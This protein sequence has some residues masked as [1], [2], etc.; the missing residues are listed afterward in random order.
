[1]LVVPR[2]PDFLRY[3]LV[4]ETFCAS[5]RPSTFDAAGPLLLP[6]D[7]AVGARDLVGAPGRARPDA[8]SAVADAATR[9]AIGFAARAAVV[10]VLFFTLSASK[11]PQYV[12]R[13]SCRWRCSSRSE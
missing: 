13:R 9:C 5:P 11:R 10:I 7:A 1:V 3:A 12:I 4:D 6:P 8:R 2:E